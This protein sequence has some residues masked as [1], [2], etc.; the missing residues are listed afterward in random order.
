MSR[1]QFLRTPR[2]AK[3]KQGSRDPPSGYKLQFPPAP[4]F[5]LPVTE[6]TCHKAWPGAQGILTQEF[7]V[8]K[9]GG[10]I[11]AFCLTPPPPHPPKSSTLQGGG[12]AEGSKSENSLGDHFVN[13]FLVP[14]SLR[15]TPP[16][17]PKALWPQDS[18]DGPGL[19]P[20]CQDCRGAALTV[21]H[22]SVWRPSACIWCMY[23]ASKWGKGTRLCHDVSTGAR[24][25][26]TKNTCSVINDLQNP[27][28][29]WWAHGWCN[30]HWV[31]WEN[32]RSNAYGLAN[33]HLD[34]TY[35]IQYVYYPPCRRCAHT[36]LPVCP[37]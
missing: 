21:N 25:R 14:K 13:T 11:F 26:Y 30:P 20:L 10:Q 9:R 3:K 33:T 32:T 18:A 15:C 6:W 28:S 4:C 19:D 29:P 24:V 34:L 8:K 7:R 31:S 1:K 37:L 22:G 35:W 27:P 23:D 16:P 5:P 12:G 36:R 17:P 2:W